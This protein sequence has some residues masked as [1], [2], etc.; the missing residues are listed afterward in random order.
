MPTFNQLVKKG[1]QT[2]VKK[3]TAPAL[4]RYPFKKEKYRCICSAEER[5]MYSS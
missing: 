3:S 2:A 5:C 1:R 4:K